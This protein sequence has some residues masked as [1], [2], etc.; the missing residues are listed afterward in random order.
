VA[1]LEA[2]ETIED[3]GLQRGPRAQALEKEQ[4]VAPQALDLVLDRGVGHP[5]LLGDLA[6]SAAAPDPEEEGAQQVGTAQPVGGG[7]GL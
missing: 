7:E 6:Q 5:E 2:A 4:A 1:R 3:Q